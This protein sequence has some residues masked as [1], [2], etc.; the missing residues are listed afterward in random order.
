[1]VDTAVHICHAWLLVQDMDWSMDELVEDHFPLYGVV[2]GV[3]G[4]GETPA[5][6]RW[7]STFALRHEIGA[8]AAAPEDEID[9]M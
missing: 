8:T 1:V 5:S 9:M 7:I 4:K 3:R 2:S 6:P